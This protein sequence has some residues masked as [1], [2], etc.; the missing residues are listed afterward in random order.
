VGSVAV[1]MLGTAVVVGLVRIPRHEVVRA[2]TPTPLS[3]YGSG[4]TGAR[5]VLL[6]LAGRVRE[7]PD[8]TGRGTYGYVRT[9][10][11]YLLTTRSSHD[12]GSAVVPVTEQ[13][14]L[15]RD[16]SGWVLR[17]PGTPYFPSPRDRVE[18]ERAGRPEPGE[19][20]QRYR[21]GLLRM[22]A[23]DRLACY[24]PERLSLDE[25]VLGKQLAAAD[26]DRQG[27]ADPLVEISDLNRDLPLPPSLTAATIRLLAGVPGLDYQGDTVDR[28]GRH[29]IAFSLN[30]IRSG[31]PERYTLVL[32]PA[33]GRLLDTDETLTG[34]GDRLNV[35]VPSVI[36]YTVF[37]DAVRTNRLLPP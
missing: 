35:K 36:S 17:E 24:V 22:T 6:D 34:D 21:W 3:F 11:W 14:W 33:T 15:S 37:L 5:E 23:P 30:S 27:A 31:L 12:S 10:G 1:A 7:L 26:P 19:F 2:A 20:D 25:T 16:D 8:R 4:S 9:Q 29:G 13:Q 18:W 28:A 32:D